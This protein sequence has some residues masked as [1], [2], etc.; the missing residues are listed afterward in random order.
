MNQNIKK[1]ITASLLLNIILTLIKTTFGYIGGSASLFSDG[2]NSLSDVALSLAMLFVMKKANQKADY[3]HPYGHE[4]YEGFLNVVLGLVIMMTAC[5]IMFEG[6]SSLYDFFIH[7]IESEKPLSITI[8]VALVSIMIKLMLAWMNVK[9]SKKYQSAILKTDSKNHLADV[10]ATLASLAGIVFALNGFLYVEAIASI[11][12]GILIFISAFKVL[13]EA[14]TYL[15]D[16]SPDQRVVEDIRSF[17]CSIEGVKSVDDLKVRKHMMRLYVDIEIG[18]D[19]S[20]TFLKAHAIA[21]RVHLACEKEFKEIIHCMVHANP[22]H[23]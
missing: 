9:A 19:Y 10:L 22:N 21:E 14:K 11:L 13:L 6:L 7:H 18:V 12:I 20:L 3:D 16:E 5:L 4:K 8:Y 23:E 2:I 15:V 17:V 1:I